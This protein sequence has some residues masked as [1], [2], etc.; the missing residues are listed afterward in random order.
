VSADPAAL[1]ETEPRSLGLELRRLLV[2]P[3]R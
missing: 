3:A 1:G 2:K